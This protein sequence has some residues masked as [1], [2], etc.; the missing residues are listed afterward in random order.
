MSHGN[1]ARRALPRELDYRPAAAAPVLCRCRNLAGD[2]S[3][4]H[5]FAEYL[6]ALVAAGT[7]N[8]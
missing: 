7:D 5:T 4:P 8:T 2:C 6:A 3:A 1:L